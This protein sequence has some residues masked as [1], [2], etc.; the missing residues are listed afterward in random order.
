MTAPE[1][2]VASSEL[3]VRPPDNSTRG[4]QP[5]RARGRALRLLV[6]EDHRPTLDL[7]LEFLDLLGHVPS[8]VTSAE[9]AKDRFIEGVFD[10][11]LIDVNLPALS[12]LDLVRQLRHRERLPV[13]IVSG[14]TEPVDHLLDGAVWLRKPFT[15]EQ[16]SQ[17]LASCMSA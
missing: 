1:M 15:Q 12:G 10:A 6:V 9:G 4:G 8:G 14:D 7:M 16:L 17:A 11:L 2:A 13:I 3:P 5:E